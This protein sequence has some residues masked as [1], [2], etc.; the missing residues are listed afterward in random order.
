LRQANESGYFETVS[1]YSNE[2]IVELVK[3][4]KFFFKLWGARGF[5]FWI[6]KPYVLLQKLSEIPENEY[7]IYL[8]QGFHIQTSG[9]KKLDEY[10]D[11]VESTGSW[12]GV[13]SAGENY[14]PEFFVRQQSVKRHNPNFYSGDFGEY[15]YAGALIIRNEDRARNALEEWRQMCEGTRLWA[16]IPIS[17]GQR[18]EFIGQD[19]DNGYLPVVL[20]KWG[21]YYKFPSDEINLFNHEGFQLHHVLPSEDHKNLDWSQMLDRPFLL[22]RDRYIIP[23]VPIFYFL[24]SENSTGTTTPL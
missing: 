23:V 15:V 6:W 24:D 1:V 2:H 9:Q 20:D 4:R 18:R 17:L 12:A 13:F 10:I 8:D 19:G 7:L 21:G 5:G 22:K 11:T 14:R 3:A 16:P